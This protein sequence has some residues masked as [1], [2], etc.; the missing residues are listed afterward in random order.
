MKDFLEPTKEKLLTFAIV[1]LLYIIGCKLTPMAPYIPYMENIFTV[2]VAIIA[3][4]LLCCVIIRV[5]G[6]KSIKKPLHN[7][8]KKLF[9]KSV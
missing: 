6:E 5:K 9:D 2:L 8:A 4:Y 7:G 1:T 3:L